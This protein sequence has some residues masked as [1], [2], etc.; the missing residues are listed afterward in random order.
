MTEQNTGSP[1]PDTHPITKH[2]ALSPFIE[3]DR[4]EW[5]RLAGETPMPLTE[6]EIAAYRGLGDPL[7]LV[8]VSEVFRPLSRLINQYAI[9]NGEM[10]RRT[11]RFL[12]RGRDR[13]SPFVVGIAGSV[14]VGKSTV[15]RVL[16]DMLARWP[17]TPEVQLVTT[18]GFLY[19]NA[20]L[21]RRG[22]T[23]R[24]G[25]PESYDRRGLLRFVS[26]IKSGATEVSAPHYSH[27]SYDIVP[28]EFT[29]VR[30]PDI[31]IIEG[32][33]VLQPASA[34]RPLAVSDLFDFSIYVDARTAD[35]EQWFTERFLKL[36][37]AAFSNPNS[38]FR[39]FANLET[40]EA[41]ALAHEYWKGINEP[42][43]IENI[44]PTRARASLVL[45]KEADH[46]IQKVL[47]R[48]L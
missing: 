20:E 17:E 9:A 40:D 18:D 5:S 34:E 6:E 11:R 44:R 24:K 23:H 39:R 21:E 4:A 26:Q 42:N 16:R 2:D 35:I 3:I 22:I 33:N 38:Y 43:L 47:L 46:R 48:K 12:K 29:V 8:E 41:R 15:A 31:L 30:R 45:R 25:F 27:L 19:P 14:A 32:L 13:P 37:K 10:H 1:A 7:D 28:G 36:R